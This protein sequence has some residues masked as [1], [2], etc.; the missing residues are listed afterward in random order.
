MSTIRK[1][2]SKNMVEMSLGNKKVLFS[3]ETPVVVFDGDNYF[4]TNEKFST[5]TTRQ[6]NFYMRQESHPNSRNPNHLTQELLEKLAK[7]LHLIP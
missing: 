7:K 3:Y 2:G 4:I 6:I 5:T 1:F